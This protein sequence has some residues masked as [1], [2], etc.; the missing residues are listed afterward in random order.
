VSTPRKLGLLASL[1][2]SQGLPFGLFTQA[3]PVILRRPRRDARRALLA[4]ARSPNR[5]GIAP[6]AYFF[7]DLRP[8]DWAKGRLVPVIFSFSW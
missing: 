8:A 3:L 1:Y 5:A 4:R 2:L 7:P 6:L